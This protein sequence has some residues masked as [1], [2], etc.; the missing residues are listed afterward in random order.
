MFVVEG[1]LDDQVA[2]E[3]YVIPENH[4]VLR[5]KPEPGASKQLGGLQFC[6]ISFQMCLS[7]LLPL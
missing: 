2:T 6:K 1:L 7:L 3:V 4:I 5:V